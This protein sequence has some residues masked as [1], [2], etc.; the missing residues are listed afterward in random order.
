M[1][2]PILGG[3][4]AMKTQ[5]FRSGASSGIAEGWLES[6]VLYLAWPEWKRF[7]ILQPPVIPPIWGL[8]GDHRMNIIKLQIMFEWSL[9]WDGSLAGGKY[10]ISLPTGIGRK[11]KT[12]LSCNTSENNSQLILHQE[13]NA[14]QKL[15]SSRDPMQMARTVVLPT[16]VPLSSLKI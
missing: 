8:Q 7:K 12:P 3:N 4:T 16:T 1:F 6:C 2:P 10:A 13:L 5:V 9:E 14:S 15:S 11:L